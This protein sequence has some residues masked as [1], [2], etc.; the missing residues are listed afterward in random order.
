MVLVLQVLD[1]EVARWVGTEPLLE[2]DH[3]LMTVQEEWL[4]VMVL[5]EVL[6]P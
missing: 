6:H 2:P 1:G 3:H 5:Q 4:I